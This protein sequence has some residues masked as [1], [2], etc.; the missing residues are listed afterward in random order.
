MHI[1][2]GGKNQPID[3]SKLH[4][5]TL[6]EIHNCT[7]LERH[8]REAAER[9]PNIAA[10][11]ETAITEENIK[12]IRAYF[13]AKG[14]GGDFTKCSPET[15]QEN[16]RNSLEIIRNHKKIVVFLSFVDIVG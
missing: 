10:Y 3:T 6:I 15:N 13:L 1:S 4:G 2:H 8:K 16:H 12:H 11:E 7:S 5:K 9:Q 14:W